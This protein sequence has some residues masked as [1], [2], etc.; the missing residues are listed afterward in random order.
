MKIILLLVIL[1]QMKNDIIIVN[2]IMV[3]LERRYQLS[4]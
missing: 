4:Y 1:F 2:Y 3:V